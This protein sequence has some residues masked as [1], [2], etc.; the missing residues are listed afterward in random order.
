MIAATVEAILAQRLVRR[1]CTQCREETTLPAAMLHE[2]KLSKE[3]LE[4]KGLKFY[5]GR[6]CDLCNNT[7]YKGRVGLFELMIMNDEMRE[8]IMKNASNDELREVAE[9]Y[10]MVSLRT[11]GLNNAFAGVTTADEVIRETIIDA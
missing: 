7:G 11:A 8:M 10:G 4:E 1:I 9:G 2:M 3:E 6:G 5:K